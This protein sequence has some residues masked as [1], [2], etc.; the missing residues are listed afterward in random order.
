MEEANKPIEIIALESLGSGFDLA[1]D[2]RLKF[3]K[4]CPSGG[5]GAG[6]RL[7]V[8]DEADKRDVLVPGGGTIRGV[9]EGIRFDKGD[10][11]RLKSDVLEFN[12]VY[13]REDMKLLM[14]ELLN[15]RS[16]V[17]GKIPSGYFNAVFDLTGAW[18]NDAA[19]AKCLAFDGYFISLYNLHLTASPLVL[20]EKKSSSVIPRSQLRRYLED[21][22][23][24]LFSDGKSPSLLERNTRDGKHKV[25]EVFGRMLQP[26]KMHFTA[27]TE[28]S[29]KDVPWINISKNLLDCMIRVPDKPALEDLQYFLEFQVPRQWAPLFCE[30]PLRHQRRKAFLPSLQFSFMGPK[31]HVNSTQV[32][33]SVKYMFHEK[34][35]KEHKQLNLT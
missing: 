9:P 8:L 24:Y 34:G 18:S 26:H 29:S 28:T 23:D 27:I 1:S 33:E 12:Q 19:D 15:Q 17:Q 6:G 7:V 14:S 21:L 20:Q 31:I 5:A 10:R 2:F 25:P 11:I 4:K 16:S 32:G 30:L 22:G 35:E 13:N 3:V